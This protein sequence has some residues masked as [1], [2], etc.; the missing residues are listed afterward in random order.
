MV[1]RRTGFGRLGAGDSTPAIGQAEKLAV[2]DDSEFGLPEG[3][4]DPTQYHGSTPRCE[5][6]LQADNDS[7]I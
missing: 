7:R 3:Y 5:P 6:I 2:D 4:I 1:Y